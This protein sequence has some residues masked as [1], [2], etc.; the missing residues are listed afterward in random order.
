MIEMKAGKEND[1]V[2]NFTL[3]K[4]VGLYQVL[5]PN[6]KTLFGYNMY[7]IVIVFFGLLTL[8]VCLLFPIGLYHLM[9]DVTAFILYIGCID[10]FVFSCCKV[11]NILYYIEDIWKCIDVTGFG[12]MKYK[13]YDV[14]VFKKWRR[15]CV[16][17]T[18][19]CSSLTFFALICWNSSPLILNNTKI[20]IRNLDGSYNTYRLNV[21]NVYIMA[22]EE[23]YNEHFYVYFFIE[24]I[25]GICFTYF[26]VI[27]DIFMI[28][29]CFAL[30]CQLETVCHAIQSLGYGRAMD[31]RSSTW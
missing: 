1:Y 6:T 16:Q 23:T 29:M 20:R 14:N 5:H 18:Y 2:F 27:F 19:I 24:T 28:T 25:I 9:N 30:T 3:S 22:S 17:I 4:Y 11:I 15:L 31:R 7:H 8:S 10:N 12:F 26:T 21:F 13:H